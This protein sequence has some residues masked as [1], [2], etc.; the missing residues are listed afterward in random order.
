MRIIYLFPFFILLL[1]SSCAEKVPDM[2][3][4]KK[5]ISQNKMVTLLSEIMEIEN[6]AQTK[7]VQLSS[8]N[9][10]LEKIVDSIL[11]SNGYSSVIFEQNMDY[12]GSRQDEMVEIYEKVK[13]NLLSKKLEAEKMPS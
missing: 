2:P 12:Y 13:Q 5:L 3:K 4:P 11:V 6:R 7:Y 8:F 10:P 9:K 1:E